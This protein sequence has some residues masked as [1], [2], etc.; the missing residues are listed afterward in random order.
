MQGEEPTTL[1]NLLK[2]YAGFNISVH[3]LHSATHIHAE[4]S[5]HY[6]FFKATTFVYLTSRLKECPVHVRTIS[7]KNGI[8]QNCFA[9]VCQHESL[10][11][12]L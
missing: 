9:D 6:F 12:H 4:I 1:T 7:G 5:Y 2:V 3:P 8:S 10:T 11:I